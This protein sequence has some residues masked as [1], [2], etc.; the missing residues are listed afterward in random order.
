VDN[1]GVH[2]PEWTLELVVGRTTGGAVRIGLISEV[3]ANEPYWAAGWDGTPLID[4]SQLQ[5]IV[6]MVTRTLNDRL[7]IQGQLVMRNR[8]P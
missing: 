1:Q 3:G 2:R 7:T 8:R 5:D 4:Q 6:G